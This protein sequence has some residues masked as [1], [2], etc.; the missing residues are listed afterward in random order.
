M[1]ILVL[2]CTIL[3]FAFLT[4]AQDR[5]VSGKITAVEDGSALPGVNVVLKGTANGTVADADGNF[6]ISVPTGGGTLVF[7]F[8]G[9]KTQEVL[10]GQRATVDVVMESDVEQLSEVVIT[11]QGVRQERRALGYAVTSVSS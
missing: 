7:S 5:V 11:A 1:R 6:R 9:L 3:G 4:N 10:I 8:V 2:T